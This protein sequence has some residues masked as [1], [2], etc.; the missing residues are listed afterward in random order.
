MKCVNCCIAIFWQNS[1]R[2]RSS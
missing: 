2:A 1:L